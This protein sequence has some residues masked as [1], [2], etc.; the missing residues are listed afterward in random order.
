[1]SIGKRPPSTAVTYDDILSRISVWRDYE[2]EEDETWESWYFAAFDLL[3]A[4]VVEMKRAAAL[5]AALGDA[6]M[7][8]REPTTAM[9]AAGQKA[10]RED[11]TKRS[12]TLWRA[13]WDAAASTVSRHDDHAATGGGAK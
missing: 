13:M 7:V 9:L 8:P 11:E 12:S 3:R 10:W 6:V 5:T 2:P 4:E 1:M